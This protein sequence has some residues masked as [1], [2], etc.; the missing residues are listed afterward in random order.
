MWPSHAQQ[1]Q[2]NNNSSQ[3]R[4]AVVEAPEPKRQKPPA[5]TYGLPA[6]F[7]AD[8][9]SDDEPMPDFSRKPKPQK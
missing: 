3:Q 7:F 2:P 1:Q 9:A 8:P 5:A 4:Y 6:S